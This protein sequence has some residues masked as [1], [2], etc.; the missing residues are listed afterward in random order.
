MR[1]CPAK[2]YKH[3]APDERRVGEQGRRAVSASFFNPGESV[4][5]ADENLKHRAAAAPT[6]P[7]R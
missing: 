6:A 1:H 4:Q 5:R 3:R 2:K 7:L